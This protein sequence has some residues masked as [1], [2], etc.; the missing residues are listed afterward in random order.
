MDDVAYIRE[1]VR[2]FYVSVLCTC[3]PSVCCD[4]RLLGTGLIILPIFSKAVRGHVLKGLALPRASRF[5]GLTL[6]ALHAC[7]SA[8]P[9]SARCCPVE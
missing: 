7:G 1:A 6:P 5:G 8:S 9:L 4:H 3:V 2:L